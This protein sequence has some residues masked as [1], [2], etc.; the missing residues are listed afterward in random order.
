VGS[1]HQSTL[2]DSVVL[3]EI[4]PATLNKVLAHASVQK[5][6]LGAFST[7][8]LRVQD[9]NIREVMNLEPESPCA[10]APIGLFKVQEETFVERT[11]DLEC[12]LPNEHARSA[13]PV[14]SSPALRGYVA[15]VFD[16]KGC[17]EASPLTRELLFHAWEALAR[18]L[19]STIGAIECGSGG[20][21][22]RMTFHPIQKRFDVAFRNLRIWVQQ[23]SI[24]SRRDGVT[25]IAAATKSKVLSDND[26][27][28]AGPRGV[29]AL[30]VSVAAIVVYEDQF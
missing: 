21:N 19:R 16:S 2:Y 18:N 12:G 14:H 10:Q 1:F 13:D 11:N 22:E 5:T 17:E 23:Q 27:S 20:G 4:A 28:Q 30:N 26:H 6:E 24:G 25:S 8:A 7:L 29:H 9:T 15:A 3:P